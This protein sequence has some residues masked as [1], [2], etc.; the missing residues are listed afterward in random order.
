MVALVANPP[1]LAPHPNFSN[2]RALC[3]HLQQALQRLVNPQTNVLGWSGLVMSQPIY[4]LFGSNGFHVPNYPGPIPIY[5]G[6]GTPIVNGNGTAVVDPLGNPT[7]L[8]VN[9]VTQAT[10]NANFARARNY[11]LF[12]QNVKQA[13]YNV[14]DQNTDGAF[15][16]SDDP[17]LTEWNLAMEIREILDH[18]VT[19]YGR[20]TPN[21]L[22]QN[23]KLFCSVYSLTKAPEVLFHWIKKCQE[24][25]TLG[26]DPYSP[27]QLLNNVIQLLLRCGLY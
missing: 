3:I 12:Y 27:M 26:D 25:Q 8:P 1:T 5:F 21:A 4:L 17:N 24:I 13:C 15:K 20:P 7:Y 2:L 19:T 10:I 23:N 18:M 16:V 11:W 14:L 6:Q 9:R 22:L